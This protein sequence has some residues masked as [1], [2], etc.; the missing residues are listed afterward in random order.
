VAGR[1]FPCPEVSLGALRQ[2]LDGLLAPRAFTLVLCGGAGVNAS[3][4]VLRA[5]AE[6]LAFLQGLGAWAVAVGAGSPAASAPPALFGGLGGGARAHD[7]G[8]GW[9]RWTRR[10]GLE[11]RIVAVRPDR[12]V[13]GA[14]A[15]VDDAAKALRASLQGPARTSSGAEL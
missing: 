2:R 11:G 5:S 15:S 3:T 1:L 9:V 10:Y 13:F 8:A 14:F 4:A 6:H 12:Y 7:A